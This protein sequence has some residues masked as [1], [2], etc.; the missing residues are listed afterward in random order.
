MVGAVLSLTMA[1]R[2]ALGQEE[3]T[4]TRPSSA[5]A[6]NGSYTC[7]SNLLPLRQSA[8]CYPLATVFWLKP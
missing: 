6:S 3:G 2:P 7:K 8:T 1:P 5:V 4:Q